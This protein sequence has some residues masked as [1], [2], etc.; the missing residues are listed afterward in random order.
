MYSSRPEKWEVIDEV[1]GKK[2]NRPQ[3]KIGRFGPIN[4]NEIRCLNCDEKKDRE[5]FRACSLFKRPWHSYCGVCR[6]ELGICRELD[7]AS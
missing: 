2:H 6:D 4:I 3:V 1:M 5:D 7:Y